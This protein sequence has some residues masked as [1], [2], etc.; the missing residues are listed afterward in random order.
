MS[1]ASTSLSLIGI[2]AIIFDLD[3]VITDTAEAHFEAW[4]KTFDRLLEAVEGSSFKPFESGDYRR[5]VDGKPRYEGV[6]SFLN[7]R[8]IELPWGDEDDPP[9]LESIYA[10][11]NAKNQH[12]GRFLSEGRIEV[13]DDAR[14]F[15]EWV[16][17]RDLKTAIVSSSKNCGTVVSRARLGD[18]F[19]MRVDGNDLDAHRLA[20]KPAPDMFLEAARRLDVLPQRAIVVEDAVAGVEAARNGRFG[21]I[22]GMARTDDE[23]ALGAAG[24]DMVITSFDDLDTQAEGLVMT[25]PP[26]NAL[27][28][29]EDVFERLKGSSLT[30]FLD[31]DGTLTPIVEDPEEAV[32]DE[33]MREAVRRLADIWPVSVV[34][35]RDLD[36]VRRRVDIADI[37]YA[38]SHGF[39]IL[40]ADGHKFTLE[41]GEEFLQMLEEAE[42]SLRECLSPIE[43][44]S[45]ERKRY[46][47]AVHY[48]HVPDG[49]VNAVRKQVERVMNEVGALRRT[50]GKKVF[51]L[52]PDIDWHKGKAVEWLI[53]ELGLS[54]E[55][56]VPMY[57]GDDVTDEDAFRTL[58]ERG[59]T[60]AVQEEPRPTA[61]EYRLEDPDQVGRFLMALT[62]LET[63]RRGDAP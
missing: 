52:Q 29:I 27:E 5:Y 50:D 63:D 60:I 25:Q 42:E 33:Q 18:F 3:G 49:E 20:G 21:R 15:L 61:A 37:A 43:G 62:E 12:Y 51:D 36:D 13:F 1:T 58:D 47:L 34:S 45:I 44:V 23:D 19:D 57:I 9:G 14:R 53:E 22:I 48:R 2:N 4:K 40:S 31:Y 6:Q 11:G 28:S 59:I 35:G 56:I 46:S 39:D 8:G 16:R 41:K 55:N 54:G 26:P 32:I 30:V 7:A 10:V 38:G 24:A 17:R